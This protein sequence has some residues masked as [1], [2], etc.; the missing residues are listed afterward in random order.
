MQ[1]SYV[2]SFNV[3]TFLHLSRTQANPKLFFFVQFLTFAITVQTKNNNILHKLQGLFPIPWFCKNF[4]FPVDGIHISLPSITFHLYKTTAGIITTSILIATLNFSTPASV[5]CTALCFFR[6]HQ[7]NHNAATN[8]LTG[9]IN[10][11]PYLQDGSQN[12]RVNL[13]L[14]SLFFV[15]RHPFSINMATLLHSVWK[16]VLQYHTSY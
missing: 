13:N 5:H 11:R 1:L 3:P 9:T 15:Q 4:N 8:S 10:N 12:L 14:Q 2:Q 16:Y 6:R 7:P